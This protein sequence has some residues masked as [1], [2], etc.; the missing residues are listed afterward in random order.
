MSCDVM[1]ETIAIAIYACSLRIARK[2]V[3]MNP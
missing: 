3:D 2:I 1:M